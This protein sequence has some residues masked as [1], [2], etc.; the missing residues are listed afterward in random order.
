MQ[1]PEFNLQT[2]IYMLYRK[3]IIY[4]QICLILLKNATI[5]L[6]STRKRTRIS[7]FNIGHLKK[8]SN[9]KITISV[10]KIKHLLE[11]IPLLCRTALHT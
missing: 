10:N 2:K 1:Q 8:V 7:K 6:F 9:Y 3:R 4:S 5:S 11:T